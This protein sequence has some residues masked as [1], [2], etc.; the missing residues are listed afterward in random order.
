[1][2]KRQASICPQPLTP[3]TYVVFFT[4]QYFSMDELCNQIQEHEGTGKSVIG[5]SA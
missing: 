3:C 4:R 5:S 2:H 1:V